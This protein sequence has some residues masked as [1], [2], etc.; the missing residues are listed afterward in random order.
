MR[1]CKPTTLRAFILV[2]RLASCCEQSFSPCS[3]SMHIH[4]PST[5]HK[6]QNEFTW[7]CKLS[8][9]NLSTLTLTHWCCAAMKEPVAKREQDVRIPVHWRIQGAWGPGPPLPQD[10]F[11]NHAVFR[12]FQGKTPILSKFWAQGPPPL[13]SKLQWP[14]WQKSWIRL[15]CASCQ[16]AF[17]VMIPV[18]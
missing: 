10:F 11:Q 8:A 16:E 7:K 12:Q 17:T 4:L 9:N 3:W 13:G 2:C 6:T 18:F 15:C 1:I 14:P 5:R